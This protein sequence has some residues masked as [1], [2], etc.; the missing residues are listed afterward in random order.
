MSPLR[1]ARVNPL[2]TPNKVD[3]GAFPF[4]R[5][6]PWAAS[7]RMEQMEKKRNDLPPLALQQSKSLST[8][9]I[10]D[11][12]EPSLSGRKSG[13]AAA[14]RARQSA[15][16]ARAV[17][18]EI[19]SMKNMV[20]VKIDI[21][22][23]GEQTGPFTSPVDASIKGDTVPVA[24]Q[25]PVES[26]R[27]FPLVHA[28]QDEALILNASLIESPGPGPGPSREPEDDP[29]FEPVDAEALYTFELF[30]TDASG[31]LDLHELKSGL[32]K[33]ESIGIGEGLLAATN[34]NKDG[35]VQKH[36]WTEHFNDMAQT[37]GREAAIGYL[38]RLDAA[39]VLQK[40]LTTAAGRSMQDEIRA[41]LTKNAMRVMDLFRAWDVDGNG[42]IN[43]REYRK[44]VRALRVQA[45]NPQ[46]DSV[47]DSW[48][49]NGNG[50][51]DHKELYKI[52]RPGGDVQLAVELQP[53]AAGD[54][55]LERKNKIALRTGAQSGPRARGGIQPTIENIKA[56][57]AED[58][59]RVRDL[60]LVI[61][62]NEDGRVTRSEFFS[63]LPVLGFD[64]GGTGALEVLFVTLDSDVN[65]A[66][67]FAELKSV[68]RRA[69]E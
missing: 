20:P 67:E 25:E 59:W 2:L 18:E 13:Q 44:A 46:I 39:A 33:F 1:Q 48:D 32:Q 62:R 61:D 34:F 45:P 8:L 57:M 60:M 65:G 49:K 14:E 17:L 26:A 41:I 21:L 66:I 64:A 24:L 43:K 37:Q 7:F 58:R 40:P 53:G 36:E 68:L 9:R 23:Q 54:I 3:A 30:D 11:P 52:L 38:A 6:A 22:N 56:A 10:P 29:D 15:S 51:I 4:A 16:H 50:S 31:S 12:M 55:E 47:F 35:N 28:Q 42:A 69:L 63:I 19:R 27:P 5:S